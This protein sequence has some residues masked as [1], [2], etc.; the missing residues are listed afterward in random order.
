M[1]EQLPPFASTRAEI[2]LAVEQNAIDRGTLFMRVIISYDIDG[3]LDELGQLALQYDKEEW[4]ES[5]LS[6]GIDADALN[7]LD[8]NDPPIPYV[9]Y[10]STP[11]LLAAHPHLIFYY[12]NVAMLSSK[13]MRGIGLD[14][15]R[16]ESGVAVPTPAEALELS[17]YFNEIVSALV[18]AGGVSPRRHVL[19]LTANLGD[20]LGGMSRNEVGRTAMM[21]LL[22]PLV[23]FLHERLLLD[24]ISFSY[25]G[26]LDEDEK[27]DTT[28]G[29][30]SIKLTEDIDLEGLFGEFERKRVKYHELV[31]RSGS[32][33][34]IDRQLKWEDE[35]GSQHK[36]GP[37]L[38]STTQTQD[39]VW[40]AEV[41]GGADPAG[42]DEHWK[43][44]T[45][46]LNRILAAAQVSKRPQPALAFVATIL[47]DRVARSAQRWIDAGKLTA[48]YNLTQMLND[49]NEMNRF[50]ADVTEFLNR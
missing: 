40:A 11:R 5:A 10:F 17:T 42:S 49:K 18:L 6:I 16:Y 31:L 22:N 2:K 30:Q 50:C 36:I 12:R 15:T 4:H 37:D 29:R 25:K 48:A 45:E 43:T 14:T 21:R 24:S 35:S 3:M 33:L 13:V 19:M 27:D 44:A 41:K 32:R 47:V 46:A 8:N 34:L 23:R 39:F 26:A 7:L 9:N 38:H 20:S 28:V 1:A